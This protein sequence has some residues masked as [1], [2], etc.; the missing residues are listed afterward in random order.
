LDL[1]NMK[2]SHA[3]VL[4]CSCGAS[5]AL[6]YQSASNKRPAFSRRQLLQR[7]AAATSASTVLFPALMTQLIA[8]QTALA[9]GGFDEEIASLR[10]TSDGY[11]L[12]L[13]D[14]DSFVASLAAEDSA[15]L[16]LAPQVS[17]VTFQKL[18]KIAH[19]VDGKIEADDFPYLAVEYAELAGAARDY[20]KLAKLGRVGENGGP[21]VALGYARDCAEKM[22]EASVVLDTLREAVE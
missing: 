11:H 19:A 10:I 18:S 6:A 1:E 16:T 5:S 8:P 7:T 4:L 21:E 3:I 15:S 17:A 22:E 14:R 2:K 13:K 12:A 20:F 9:R